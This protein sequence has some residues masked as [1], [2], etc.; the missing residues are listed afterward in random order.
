MKHLVILAMA[1]LIATPA[2]AAP[3]KQEP[4]RYYT[5]GGGGG[6][7]GHSGHLGVAGCGLGAEVVKDHGKWAQ[8]GASFLNGTG[9]QTFAISFGTSGCEEDGMVSQA[10]EKE[11]F[12]EANRAD[13]QR[14]LAVGG[15]EYVSSLANLYGCQGDAQA[16]FA[17]TLSRERAALDGMNAGQASERIQGLVQAELAGRCAI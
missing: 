16:A 9:M 13:I 10:K 11:M 6:S 17:D 14:E 12:L 7:S 5:T 1:A 3:K 8:V 2:L 4:K 15:G